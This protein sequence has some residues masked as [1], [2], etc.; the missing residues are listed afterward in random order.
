MKFC[1]QCNSPDLS[2]KACR[3][4]FSLVFLYALFPLL[5]FVLPPPIH[6]LSTSTQSPT[7]EANR[8]RSKLSLVNSFSSWNHLS[9]AI[10]IQSSTAE[11]WNELGNSTSQICHLLPYTRSTNHTTP[12]H[13]LLLR[14]GR[15]A[16][17]SRHQL[18]NI[19]SHPTAPSSTP[20]LPNITREVDSAS[21]S[22]FASLLVGQ[23]K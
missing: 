20:H 15:H 12:N 5:K 10:L 13:S 11:M 23:L 9:C 7:K 22:Q 8:L 1:C 19:L 17:F 3:L 16:T 4:S 14:S 21:E 6:M 2:S 18:T